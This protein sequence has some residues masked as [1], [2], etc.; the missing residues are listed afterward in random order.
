MMEIMIFVI[1]DCDWNK[2]NVITAGDENGEDNNVGMTKS[3]TF[4]KIMILAG[5][6]NK[7]NIFFL[8]V[9]ME[10]DRRMGRMPAERGTLA[11]LPDTTRART[12]V[13]VGRMRQQ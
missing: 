4:V 1:D 11:P 2:N 9:Q 13:T 10:R 3:I 6:L 12:P 5:H 8:F 7:F